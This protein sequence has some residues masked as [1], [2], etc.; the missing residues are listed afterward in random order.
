ML[1]HKGSKALARRT[2]W[3][4]GTTSLMPPEPGVKLWRLLQLSGNADNCLGQKWPDRKKTWTTMPVHESGVHLSEKCYFFYAWTQKVLF[5]L[6][7]SAISFTLEPQKCYILYGKC[8]FF[9]ALHFQSL[10]YQI[11]EPLY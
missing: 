1:F 6:R 11:F 2:C 8:H 3:L 7:K 10:D 5:L 4:R 9:Y